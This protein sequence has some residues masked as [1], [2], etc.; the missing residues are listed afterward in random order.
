MATVT[1]GP[2]LAK[3]ADPADGSSSPPKPMA[4]LALKQSKPATARVRPTRLSRPRQHTPIV[5][6]WLCRA[7]PAR[8]WT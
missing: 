2:A 6:D 1:S 4:T 8:Q 7:R 3:L 5:G